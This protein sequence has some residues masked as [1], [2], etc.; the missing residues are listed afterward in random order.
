MD[1]NNDSWPDPGFPCEDGPH[2]DGFQSDGGNNIVIRHNVI[3]VPCGQTSAI[4]M[5]T[6]TS[7]IGNVTVEDN[8][9]AGGG[10]TLYCD[11]GA[12]LFGTNK[13]T[14]NRFAKTYFP[15]SGY[16]GPTTG[17]EP[18]PTSGNVWDVDESPVN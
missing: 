6:N 18:Y 8:L 11:A 1:S 16:W 10:Y 9:M 13:F 12:N 14:S 2:Y 4:L 15:R 5:S 17:C 3:R 7:P